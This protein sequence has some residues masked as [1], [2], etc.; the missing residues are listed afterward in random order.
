[1]IA[2][3]GTAECYSDVGYIL[4]GAILQRS[5]G[6]DLTAWT[7][8][9]L[10]R[11][12]GLSDSGFVDLACEKSRAW[13]P[14]AERTAPCG[15]CLWRG[16]QIRGVVQDE[17]AYA[18]GGVAGHAG[19]FGTA[20]EVFL[21][22]QQYLA[23]WLGRSSLFEPDLV[24]RLWATPLPGRSWTGGW[25]TPSPEASSAGSKISQRAVGH[26]GFTGGSIWIDLERELIV[27]V[28]SNRVHPERQQRG[29][30]EWRPS[31]HDAVFGALG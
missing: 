2:A 9:R 7:R 21:L 3:A 29:I 14:P 26:L 18:M 10:C 4:L 24:R 11:P 31:F 30:A 19:W 8:S 17:N 25:D 27:V 22:A 1:M 13:R 12:L 15:I 16:R 6:I 5:L 20:R 23:S 28:L